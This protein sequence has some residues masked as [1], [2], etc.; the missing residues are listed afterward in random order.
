MHGLGQ[1]R[2]AMH[3]MRRNS[4]GWNTLGMKGSGRNGSGLNGLGMNESGRHFWLKDFGMNG[5]EKKVQGRVAANDLIIKKSSG[6]G[7]NEK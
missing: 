2:L 4:S 1:N 3:G 5:S 7:M 6:L